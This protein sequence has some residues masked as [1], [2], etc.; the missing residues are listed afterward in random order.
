MVAGD[1][2]GVAVCRYG[3]NQFCYHEFPREGAGEL[4]R[5]VVPNLVSKR[6][7]GGISLAPLTH[8]KGK[9]KKRSI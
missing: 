9:G 3:G 5:N 8:T 1:P 7:G 4:A 2:S 6:R